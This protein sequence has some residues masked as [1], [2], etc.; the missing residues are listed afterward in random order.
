MSRSREKV[1]FAP[2]IRRTRWLLAV[3]AV[4]TGSFVLAGCTA[5]RNTLGTSSSVC[6]QAL[7]AAKQAVEGRG[8]FLGIRLV[9]RSLLAERRHRH[10][11]QVLELRAGATVNQVC[12]AA[13]EGS[14]SQ[15]DVERPLGAPPPG[16]VGRVAVVVVSSPG[17]RVLGTFVLDRRPIR[18]SHP[19]IGGA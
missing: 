3:S 10:L 12:L 14:F 1:R 16:G 5:A 11:R 17:N 4:C 13:Y 18:F 15:A 2:R 8:K 19:A 9:P 6:Y 7:P